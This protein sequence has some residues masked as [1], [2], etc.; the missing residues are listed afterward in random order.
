VAGLDDA[1]L[2]STVQLQVPTVDTGSVET[3]INQIELMQELL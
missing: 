3:G 1:N 2:M